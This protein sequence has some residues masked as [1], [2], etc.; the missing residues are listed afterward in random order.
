VVPPHVLVDV[1]HDNPLARKESFGPVAPVIR[2]RDEEDALRI[3]N[4]TEFGLAGAV[5]TR[6][7]GRGERFASAWRWEWRTSTTS[8]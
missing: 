7:L 6:D 4:D 3:A 5:F 8:R 2:A 1:A